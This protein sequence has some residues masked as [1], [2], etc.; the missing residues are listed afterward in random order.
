MNL[1]FPGCIPFLA[2]FPLFTY[3][4]ESPV[5]SPLP[6]QTTCVSIKR[7]TYFNNTAKLTPDQTAF[8]YFFHKQIPLFSPSSES[9][10]RLSIRQCECTWSICYQKHLSIR[11]YVQL[12]HLL[13]RPFRPD[14]REPSLSEQTPSQSRI[15]I[16]DNCF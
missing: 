16:P 15:E 3:M 2:S 10:Q 14:G 8:V 12:K 13:S 5:N 1:L 4:M 6:Y 11:Q 9:K 7:K